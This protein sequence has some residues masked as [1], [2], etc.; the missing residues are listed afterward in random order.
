MTHPL[1]L[2]QPW[3]ILPGVSYFGFNFHRKST[4]GMDLK[5]RRCLKWNGR[6]MKF[7][8]FIHFWFMGKVGGYIKVNN[9]SHQVYSKA[10]MLCDTSTTTANFNST[11]ASCKLKNMSEKIFSDIFCGNSLP[12]ITLVMP[13]FKVIP[14]CSHNPKSNNKHTIFCKTLNLLW[15]WD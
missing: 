1:S 15:K 11:D 13:I 9:G 4:Y 3:L 10:L 8:A 14:T 6:I 12:K 5:L 2:P 7:L